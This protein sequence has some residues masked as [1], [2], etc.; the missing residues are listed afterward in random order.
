MYKETPYSDAN[1]IFVIM[2]FMSWTIAAG[3]SIV[4]CC[5]SRL[6]L[7]DEKSHPS[8]MNGSYVTVKIG[9][10]FINGEYCDI[11]EVQQVFTVPCVSVDEIRYE[12]DKNLQCKY[13]PISSKQPKVRRLLCPSGKNGESTVGH[14][15]TK[16]H[17]EVIQ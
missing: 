8:I 2:F 14:D 3:V 5:N 15:N 12:E 7:C 11:E 13:C 16:M 17:N 4:S 9:T 1:I 6:P 10:V